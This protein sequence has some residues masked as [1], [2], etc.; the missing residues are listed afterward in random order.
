MKTKTKTTSKNKQTNPNSPQ[1]SNSNLKV[2]HIFILGAIDR[3]M[4]QA[5]I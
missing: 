3:Q 5:E 4:A 2:P 1:N